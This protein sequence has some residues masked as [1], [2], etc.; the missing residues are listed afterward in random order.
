MAVAGVLLGGLL[1]VGLT[2]LLRTLLF[3]VQPFDPISLVPAVIL[4]VLVTICASYVPARRASRVDPL[5]A[6][7]QD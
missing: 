5:V 3:Q 4:V 6:L 1:S 2:R 7:R